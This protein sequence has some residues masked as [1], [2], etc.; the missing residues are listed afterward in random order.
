MGGSPSF[1]VYGF[2]LHM[3]I[4]MQYMYIYIK[5]LIF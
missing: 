2:L 1:P 3:W 4:H 5:S